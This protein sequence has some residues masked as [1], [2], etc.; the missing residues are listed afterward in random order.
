MALGYIAIFADYVT[1]LNPS[2]G[3]RKWM[4]KYLGSLGIID[5]EK[6]PEYY[7]M[8]DFGNKNNQNKDS[9]S[10]GKNNVSSEDV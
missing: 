10:E 1:T 8:A 6:T 4:I 7:P 5:V 3:V 9:V 2:S